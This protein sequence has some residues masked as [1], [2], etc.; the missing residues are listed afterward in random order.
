MRI[1]LPFTTLR[2]TYPARVARIFTVS[3]HHVN[4]SEAAK[5]GQRYE[6]EVA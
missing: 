3:S 5:I 4:R 1:A 6:R 2:Q